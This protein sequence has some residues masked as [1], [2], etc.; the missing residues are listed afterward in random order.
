MTTQTMSAWNLD[1]TH[2][3]AQFKV[4][5]LVIS[6]VTGSFNKFE[7]HLSKENENWENANVTFSVDVNSIDTNN[8]DRDGH[9]KSADFFDVVNHPNMTFISTEFKMVSENNYNVTGHLTIKGVTKEVTLTATF[10]GEM[11][12]PW[13]N[14]KIGFEVSGVVKREE[15]GLTWS[16]VTEAGG[17]VVG[18]DVKLLFNVQFAPAQA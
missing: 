10:G 2:S 9:L 7:S 14:H 11:V 1:P 5:H 17:V 18:S 6:T 3:E 13:G 12:D 4:K 16:A 8:V 15:F